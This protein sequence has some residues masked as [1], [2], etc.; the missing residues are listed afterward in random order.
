MSQEMIESSSN[1][2]SLTS[3]QGEYFIIAVADLQL[4]DNSILE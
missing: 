1:Y 3:E 4:Q 2:S